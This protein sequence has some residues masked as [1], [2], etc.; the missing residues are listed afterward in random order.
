MKKQRVIAVLT[1]L[2]TIVTVCGCGAQQ[3]SAVTTE[4]A[5]ETTAEETTV[6]TKEALT[7][8]EQNLEMETTAEQENAVI[9]RSVTFAMLQD[10]GIGWNLGNTLDAHGG[11]SLELMSEVSWG[12]PRQ[13]QK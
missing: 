3:A 10:M 1:G 4:T 7:E 12:T 5:V 2:M 13:H 9:D 6:E 11:S 8:S